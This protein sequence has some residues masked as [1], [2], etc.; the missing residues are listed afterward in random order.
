HLSLG[1]T[2]YVADSKAQALK[3][4]G[5]HILYFNRTL[6]SHGNFTETETQR[7]TGYASQASTDYVRP[8]NQ[9][10]AANLREDFR[11]MT[12]ADLERPRSVANPSWV[13]RLM[14]RGRRVGLRIPSINSSMMDGGKRL[15]D[16][17]I[18]SNSSTRS[19]S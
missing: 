1:I 16:L 19:S 4:Y 10:A 12:M 13:Y 11:Q 5:P 15:E 7:A 14:N 8:E 6:F 9:R 2:A 18:S 3:E 17:T